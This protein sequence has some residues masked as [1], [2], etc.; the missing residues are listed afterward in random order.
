MSHSVKSGARL[1]GA[2]G[3]LLTE[4]LTTF[5]PVPPSIDRRRKN[6]GSPPRTKLLLAIAAVAIVSSA[7]GANAQKATSS[8]TA[9][10]ASPLNVNLFN[11]LPGASYNP[12]NKAT[13]SY[14]PAESGVNFTLAPFSGYLNPGS[15][16][17]AQAFNGSSG[18]VIFLDR[19]WGQRQFNK[20]R[21]G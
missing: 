13:A 15:G 8:T 21:I 6:R 11:W 16:G 12:S 10:G 9:P 18:S 5:T 20:P 17:S 1:Q 3:W 2:V 19:L 7:S 4:L 14:L